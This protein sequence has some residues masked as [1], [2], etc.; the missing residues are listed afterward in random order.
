MPVLLILILLAARPVSARQPE[1]VLI[2]ANRASPV[3]NSIAEYYARKR[4]IP[5]AQVCYIRTATTESVSRLVYETQIARPIA[6]C[7]VSRG[8]Q[9]KILYIVTTLGVPLIVEG[10]GGMEGDIAAVDSELTLLYSAMKGRPHRVQGAWPNPYFRQTDAAFSHPAF[11]IYLVTRLAGYD[12]ADVRGL[13]DRSL[14]AVNRGMAVI[15]MRS[16]LDDI[17][18]DW[19]KNAAIRLPASRTILDESDAV[20]YK[21]KNVIALASWGSN[22]KNRKQRLLGFEWLPGAIMTEFVSTNGRTFERPPADWNISTWEQKD[23]P[24]WFKQSPQTLTADY[25]HEGVTGASGHVAEPKLGFT[26]R[27]EIL[28]P[29]YINNGRNLAES[30]YLAIPALSWQN[31]V[32]GDPLCRLRQP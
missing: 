16:A 15:D 26:P 11:P 29:A 17:G 25:V 21:Q 5:A 18:N 28:L 10:A 4:G 24:K 32:V 9:E 8:L 3:S 19:L 2:V 14:A 20:L 23:K 31:I 12:F 1:N 13:I 6:R 22:D 27:P 30:Y 7:L